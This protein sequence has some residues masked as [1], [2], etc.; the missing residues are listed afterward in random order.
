MVNAERLAAI[1]PARIVDVVFA[2]AGLLIGLLVR[3]LLWV[4][5]DYFNL[6]LIKGWEVNVPDFIALA[7]GIAAFAGLRGHETAKSFLGEVV[8]ELS[9]VVWPAKKETLASAVVVIIMVGVASL[10]L[11]S[12]DIIWAWLTGKL[13]GI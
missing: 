8:N 13:L 12:I 9:K 1:S 4:V 5:W 2:V 10:I 11:V 3:Q 7:V 6:P